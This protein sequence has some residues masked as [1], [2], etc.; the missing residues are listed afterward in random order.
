MQTTSDVAIINGNDNVAVAIRSLRKGEKLLINDR[1]IQVNEDIASP[2]KIALNDIGEGDQIIKYGVPIGTALKRIAAG[3]LVHLHN[4]HSNLDKQQIYSYNP[5]ERPK[6]DNTISD[7]TFM[8]YRRASGEVG[9]RNH[10]FILPTVFCANG[11]TAKLARIANERFNL[12]ANFDGFIGFNHFSGCCEEG[13]NLESTQRILS[14]LAKNP[15]AGG[16]LF[17]SVGCETNNLDSFK[18][19]LK[20]CTERHIRFLCLQDAGDELIIGLAHLEDLYRLA[21][22]QV[23]QECHIDRLIIAMNCGGSDGYSGITAN[24]LL[25]HITD[26]I[27][28]LGASII[29][30]EVP[31]MLG[32]EQTLMNRAVNHEVYEN[33]MDMIVNH[34]REYAKH[35]V[36]VYT[37]PTGANNKG[38]ISTIEEKS[39]GCIAKGG[40]APVSGVISYGKRLKRPGLNL[41]EGPAH[42]F[43]S[44]TGQIAAGA[45]LVLFTTG[46]GTPTG[47]AVPTIKITSNSDLYKRKPQWFEYD[48][49]ELLG[50]KQIQIAA[51]ELL[52]IILSI[53]SGRA[54]TRAEENGY[55]D[56]GIL[57]SGLTL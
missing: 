33:I 49:G 24:P 46:S 39:L 2:H 13:Y 45:N 29:M 52:E 16:V 6:R 23:R 21:L 53:A 18:P 27:E 32:V 38:G 17:V 57:H 25:G 31:E 35:G 54:K 28:P 7:K 19:F 51:Q 5:Q 4:I 48:A 22:K 44:I 37:F 55:F 12:R 47:F 10:I 41:L 1:E 56:I 30:T 8:G 11:F 42:D 40:A 9:T 3:E 15:N 20:D 34:K 43:V 26:M 50:T 14:T 36:P